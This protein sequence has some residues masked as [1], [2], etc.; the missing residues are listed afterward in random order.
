MGLDM[1][2]YATRYLWD[3]PEDNEDRDISGKI[4]ELVN[5]PETFNVKQIKIE[6]GYWRKSNQIH[7]YF[8]NTIQDG[9][10]DC[11][12]YHVGRQDLKDLRGICSKVLENR[13]LAATELPTTAGFFFGSKDYDEWYYNDLEETIKILD[14]ALSLPKEWEFEYHSSW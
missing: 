5:I 8:V 6:A 4:R 9:N 10:D 1:Y 14:K 11:G 7:R 2:L 3:W 13:E 12:Y